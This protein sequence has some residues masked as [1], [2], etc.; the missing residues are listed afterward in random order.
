MIKYLS[1]KNGKGRA[2]IKIDLR[3]AFDSIRCPFIQA[4]LE[5]MNKISHLLFVDDLLIFAPITGASGRGLRAILSDFAAI[6][7][8]ELNS[9]KSTIFV[10]D[11]VDLLDISLCS[12]TGNHKGN[13]ED[14]LFILMGRPL[15]Q[16]VS[17]SRELE[18]GLFTEAR[19]GTWH[20]A[21]WRMVESGPRGPIMGSSGWIAILMGNLD[22]KEKPE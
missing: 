20:Q 21:Y 2:A 22:I 16:T 11:S 13:G 14:H 7:G 12:S 15:V 3:K 1:M 8:H 6:S 5:A 18:N 19:R 9:G 10:G 4:A 17:S